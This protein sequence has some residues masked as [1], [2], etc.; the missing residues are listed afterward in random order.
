MLTSN[1]CACHELKNDG[2]QFLSQIPEANSD[3][4]DN[5]TSEQ[6]SRTFETERSSETSPSEETQ[7]G[8]NGDNKNTSNGLTEFD[9][10]I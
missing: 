9:T 1:S 4:D 5:V 3:P 2:N 6:S 8:S 10:E 7:S